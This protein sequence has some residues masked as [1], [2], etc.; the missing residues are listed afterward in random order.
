M[1]CLRATL[2]YHEFVFICIW[3]A[4]TASPGAYGLV[5]SEEEDGFVGI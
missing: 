4:C 3:K 5:E 2:K 1:S